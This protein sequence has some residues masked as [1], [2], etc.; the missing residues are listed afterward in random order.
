MHEM[1]ITQSVVETVCERLEGAPARALTLEIG[2]LSGVVPD[3]VRFCFDMAA[4]GTAL[5]G[6]RLDITEP[7]GRARCRACTNEFRLDDLIALCGC[8]SADVEI[9]GGQELRIRSVEVL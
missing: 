1:A 3:A 7:D 2:R 5:A 6:A 8:G 9:T 4:D